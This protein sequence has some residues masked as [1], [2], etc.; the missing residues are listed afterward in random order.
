M[1]NNLG[2]KAACSSSQNKML[3]VKSWFVSTALILRQKA[4][5]KSSFWVGKYDDIKDYPVTTSHMWTDG[6]QDIAEDCVIVDEN[7][8]YFLE[9]PNPKDAVYINMEHPED[10]E[11][12][13]QEIRIYD[14]ASLIGSLGGTLGLFIGFSFLGVFDYLFDRIFAL[15]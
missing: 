2:A 15:I 11:T 7:D 13:K 14:E 4:N 3:H 6:G 9:M 1:F 8:G 12:V 10:K 5:S